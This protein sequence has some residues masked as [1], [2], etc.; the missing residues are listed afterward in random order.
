MLITYILGQATT[1]E[2]T[3]QL[4][5]SDTNWYLVQLH[6]WKNAL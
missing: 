1:S 5:C 3:S 4:C 6:R 2:T